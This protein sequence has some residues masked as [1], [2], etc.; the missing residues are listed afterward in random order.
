MLQRAAAI[1]VYVHMC[2]PFILIKST[3]II[4]PRDN[5]NALLLRRV[6]CVRVAHSISRRFKK[7]I[8]G[9]V[10][11]PSS[12]VLWLIEHDTILS[13]LFC[14]I[15]FTPPWRR[16]QYIPN[17][18]ERPK[19]RHPSIFGTTYCVSMAVEL[20]VNNCFGWYIVFLWEPIFT[21]ERPNL[22]NFVVVNSNIIPTP[23]RR[24]E[25]P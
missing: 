4:D 10:T 21:G 17:T 2:N 22:Q 14:S 7:A 24:S 16:L 1:Y 25:T 12:G 9:D 19:Q 23:S 6:W 20:R 13:N 8:R 3:S 11:F 5:G 15:S 18:A